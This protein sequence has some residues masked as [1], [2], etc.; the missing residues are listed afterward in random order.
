MNISPERDCRRNWGP[1]LINVLDEMTLPQFHVKFIRTISSRDFIGC[2]RRCRGVGVV[3]K[4]T[5]GKSITRG[6]SHYYLLTLN[7]TS[8]DEFGSLFK[9]NTTNV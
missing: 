3:K 7:S 5:R 9:R 4:K 2:V 8:D 1:L 6:H